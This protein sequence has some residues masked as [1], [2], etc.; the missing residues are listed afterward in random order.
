MGR[1]E[2]MNPKYEILAYVSTTKD[3]LLGG[4]QLSLLAK[5]EKELTQLTTDISNGL[6][7]DVIKLSNG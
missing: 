4:K 1:E 5:D 3:R 6:K 7:A 2:T